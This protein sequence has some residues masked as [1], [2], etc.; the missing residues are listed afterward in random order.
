MSSNVGYE[1][2]PAHRRR[3]ECGQ[4]TSRSRE[5]VEENYI[6]RGSSNTGGLQISPA[7]RHRNDSADSIERVERL[8]PPGVGGYVRLKTA[9]R[10]SGR[11]ARSA[12]RDQYDDY[13]ATSRELDYYGKKSRR[14]YNDRR[15]YCTSI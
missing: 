4:R 6:Q 10:E 3:A 14:G 12:C 13:D 9:T 5:Y 8:I 1:T 7:Q 15:E 11:R 2:A